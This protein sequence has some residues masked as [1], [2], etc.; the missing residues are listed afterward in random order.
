MTTRS[1]LQFQSRFTGL[2]ERDSGR[3]RPALD[4]PLKPPLA[5][6]MRYAIAPSATQPAQ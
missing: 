2:A 6:S 1:V 4:G 5:C 3:E